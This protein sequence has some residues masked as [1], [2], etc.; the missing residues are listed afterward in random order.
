VDFSH[1]PAPFRTMVEKLKK[2][3]KY[4]H[5][6]DNHSVQAS[7]MFS[8]A[9][10]T[11]DDDD[12][13]VP[14]PKPAGKKWRVG[15]TL[16]DSDDSDDGKPEAKQVAKKCRTSHSS[17]LALVSLERPLE[18]GPPVPEG[19]VPPVGALPPEAARAAA[20]KRGCPAGSGTKIHHREGQ[21]RKGKQEPGTRRVM[22]RS[23]AFLKSVAI[24]PV[25][26]LHYMCTHL[27][28]SQK[29]SRVC[30]RGTWII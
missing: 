12:S 16:E 21:R 17:D 18:S 24:K 8:T 19:P 20:P 10:A 4:T 11:L 9:A 7:G 26:S 28:L 2:E 27:S 1:R 23:P 30:K 22:K 3:G 14:A 29:F 15:P 5:L 25:W 13:D 6:V